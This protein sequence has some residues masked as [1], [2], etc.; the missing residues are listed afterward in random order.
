MLY[1]LERKVLKCHCLQHKTHFKAVLASEAV[2][3][4]EE[5]C[6]RR[7]SLE[8]QLCSVLGAQG[9]SAAT[10][11]WRP[12]VPHSALSCECHHTL[13]RAVSVTTHYTEHV[14]LSCNMSQGSGL[15][16]SNSLTTKCEC[17]LY[18]LWATDEGFLK[19]FRKNAVPC[20]KDNR[21]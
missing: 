5:A 1:S 15:K 14:L 18:N 17:R 11:E 13:H 3:S 19:S 4:C 10:H 16:N 9:R 20:S 8:A 21:R 12:V 2:L 7:V 6:T